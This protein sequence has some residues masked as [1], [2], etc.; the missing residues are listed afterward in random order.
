MRELIANSL[1]SDPD[2]LVARLVTEGVVR[3]LESV[4]IADHYRESDGRGLHLLVKRTREFL[5]SR[6]VL[7]SGE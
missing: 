6:G 3:L 4:N 5:I 2:K 1:D 7:Y